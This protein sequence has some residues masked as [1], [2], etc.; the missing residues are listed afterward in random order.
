MGTTFFL[1]AFMVLLS[2]LCG[3][4]PIVLGL[5]A[6]GRI[7]QS[8]GQLRGRGLAITAIVLG[9]LALLA[10]PLILV[11]G[12]FVGTVPSKPPTVTV[13]SPYGGFT[14]NATPTPMPAQVPAPTITPGPSASAGYAKRA[15]AKEAAGDT[16]GAAA[17]YARAAESATDADQAAK[18]NMRAHE[19]R[20]F[21][22]S[23]MKKVEAAMKDVEK[24]LDETAKQLDKN[25]KQLEKMGE[26]LNQTDIVVPPE[27]LKKAEL[28]DHFETINPDKG[29]AAKDDKSAVKEPS[30]PAPA[31]EPAEKKP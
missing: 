18:Y 21:N 11:L 6:L 30:N 23:S 27:I 19:L 12:F 28:G 26:Q 24:Q 25:G 1:L 4:V 22:S 31:P 7:E 15:K 20:K 14:V 16:E 17:D 29:P 9:I 2:C 5:V 10:L 3:P 13:S 8:R